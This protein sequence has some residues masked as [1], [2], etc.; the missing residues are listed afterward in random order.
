MFIRLIEK[1]RIINFF[2]STPHFFS[3]VNAITLIEK[4]RM[5]TPWAYMPMEADPPQAIPAFLG[6]RSIFSFS[7]II[8]EKVSP[9]FMVHL[10]KF[11]HNKL[12]CYKNYNKAGVLTYID[13]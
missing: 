2:N 13:F 6:F 4:I 10:K 7:I 11:C 3:F 5:L 1:N 12:L 9:Q 8:V